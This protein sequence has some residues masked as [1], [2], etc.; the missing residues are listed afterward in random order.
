MPTRYPTPPLV[1]LLLASACSSDAALAPLVV[2]PGTVDEELKADEIEGPRAELKVMVDEYW[3]DDVRDDLGLDE[4]LAQERDVWF[5]DSAELALLDAGVILR[6]RNVH[7]DDDDSTVKIRP[8]AAEDVDPAWFQ[9]SGFKCELD[10]GLT[11]AVSS[12]SLTTTQDEDEIE[13]VADGDRDI[14]SLFS[15]E[16]EDFLAEHGPDVD[17]DQLVAFGGIDALVWKL[18]SDALPDK[19]TAEHWVLPG[20]EML[21]LSVK[22]PADEAEDSMDQLLAWL[23]D[24]DVPLSAEQDSKTRRALESLRDAASSY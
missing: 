2:G 22:V 1:V 23:A 20:G 18:E 5:Y 24:R 6:A 4:D 11:T 13:E 8:L 12:C 14:D 15:S 3:I 16:Q 19:M 17:W 9:Q 7:G 21:E 10:A